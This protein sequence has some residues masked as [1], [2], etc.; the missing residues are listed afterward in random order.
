MGTPTG[1]GETVLL[2]E[3]EEVLLAQIKHVLK[4]LGYAVLAARTPSEAMGLAEQHAGVI[5][6]LIVDVIMPEMNGR[7]LSTR[8]KEMYPELST[9]FM[10]GYTANV[11][12]H[13]DMLGEGARFLQKP[14]SRHDLAVMIREVLTR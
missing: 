3:D 4:K 1:Q 5:D 8:L 7:D 6:L 13:R 12:T 10:S 2:V 11:V 14:F 9:L